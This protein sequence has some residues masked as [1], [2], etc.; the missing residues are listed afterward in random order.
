VENLTEEV[1]V[2]GKEVLSQVRAERKEFKQRV[3]FIYFIF[4][5]MSHKRERGF[6]LLT[7]AS[8][9]MIPIN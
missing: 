3:L 9:G 6:E 5:E 7:F 2:A 4:F 1:E 8:L